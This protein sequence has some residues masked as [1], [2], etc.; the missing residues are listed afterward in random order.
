MSSHP[1]E[2]W[3]HPARCVQ[4]CNLVLY[5]GNYITGGPSAAYAIY[6]T[7]TGGQGS[8]C[9]VTVNNGY[10]WSIVNSAG[11]TVFQRP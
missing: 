8:Q 7:G 5:N 9:R 3:Q 11:Q 10:T 4:D 2:W 1:R 6:N